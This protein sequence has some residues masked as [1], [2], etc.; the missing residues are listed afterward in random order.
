MIRRAMLQSDINLH[1]RAEGAGLSLKTWSGEV[2]LDVE[3]S[4]LGDIALRPSHIHLVAQQQRFEVRR[5]DLNTSIARMAASGA[6]DLAGRTDLQ[7][8]LTAELAGL[9]AL[10]VTLEGSELGAQP[11]V[12]IHLV[13]H[14]LQ[15]GTLLVERIGLDAAYRGAA[16]EVRFAADV[17]Q[18]SDAGGRANGAATLTDQG[19]Q[20]VVEE[21]VARLPGRT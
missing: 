10:Q 2:Q 17:V 8:E 19:Q 1:A 14:Q 11:E 21:L 5:F 20:A 6:L 3:P 12:R 15:A 13:A 18:S 4:H 16:G 7:Y 9:Q